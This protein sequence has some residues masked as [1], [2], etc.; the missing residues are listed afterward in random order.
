M[1]CRSGKHS[2][3]FIW[4]LQCIFSS[5][6]FGAVKSS[7]NID[8]NYVRVN[9]CCEINELKVEDRCTHVNET[10]A[11]LWQPIFTGLNGEQKVQV[12]FKFVTGI[13]QCGSTE[14]RHIY[15]Y[16][17][18]SDKLV[19]LSN[20]NLR[21]YIDYNVDNEYYYDDEKDGSSEPTYYDYIPGLYCM[22]KIIS[23]DNKTGQYASVCVPRVETVWKDPEFLIHKIINPALHILCIAIL[24]T[25][26]VIYFVLPTL[27]DLVG[28]IIT[29]MSMC[30][31]I[32]QAADLVRIYTEFSSHVSFM[33]ADSVL[34]VSLQATFF[35]LS[36]LG[37]Y[38]W[39]TFRSRNVFLRVTDGRK[40]CW[41][42][43]YVWSC[44]TIMAAL[45]LFA[46]Y[47][48]D[49]VK[50]NNAV[51]DTNQPTVGW[52]GIAVFF[53]PIAFII[54]VNIFFYV[55]THKI[56]SRMSTYGRIHHKLKNNFRIFLFLF[57]ILS[58]FWM[59]MLLSWLNFPLL[60][61]THVIINALHAPAILYV[62]VLSQK[63]VTFLLRKSCCY[64][65]EAVPQ[66]EWG[67][68]MT[69]MNG[70]DY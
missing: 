64:G 32:T 59:S 30:L 25:V 19:L 9:K 51:K 31:I 34:Y 13:P 40:Y 47:T 1:Y 68:E 21:H 6:V 8:E 52:L 62:C 5:V 50:T 66:N 46:H 56:I 12:K 65:Q 49:N 38:I 45:A 48:L 18:S 28:N 17:A 42:S 3:A 60:F 24:L 58:I 7:E 43:G 29:T 70:F 69:H 37:Y 10:S 44:T 57:I 14:Q 20:G 23:N 26:A 41:Y 54:L 27:R 63:H 22:D 36:G 61:Y 67:D 2:F 16:A 53:T 35:W 11:E 39:S 15:H 33:V 4:I 55:T